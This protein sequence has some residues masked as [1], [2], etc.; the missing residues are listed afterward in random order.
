MSDFQESSRRQ[1][2]T[3]AAVAHTAQDKAGEGAEL[4][5]GKAAEVGGT[6]KEQAANVV[7]EATAQARSLVDD[8]RGQL[9][10]QAQSQTER[11]AEN[12][13][14]LA[15]ELREM[16][17]GGKPDSTMA[18]VARQLADGGEQAAARMEQ[19]GPDGLVGDLQDFAR[20]RPGAFLAGAAV[21]GFLVG[22]TGK[23]VGAASSPDTGGRTDTG[24]DGPGAPQRAPSGVAPAARSG[25]PAGYEDLT[26]TYGQSQP[27]HVVPTPPSYPPQGGTQPYG[28]SPRPGE[29]R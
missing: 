8:L 22:R 6:A 16:S 23:G 21:A 5:G 11:L 3:T 17:E 28:G 15:R 10:G 13:R 27:P 24:G 29:G 9:Q 19:R 7:G 12:V 25:V 20:R 26:D 2:S 18:G 1:D 14:R 4:V